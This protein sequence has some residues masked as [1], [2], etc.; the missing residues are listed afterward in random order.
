MKE[1]RIEKINYSPYF[2]KRLSRL[3]PE[4]IERAQ[5]KENLFKS[6]AFAPQLNTHKLKGRDKDSWA[7]YI[8]YKYRIKFIFISDTEA[9]FIDV[10]AHDEVY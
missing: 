7:F 10:G 8:D 4:L 2:L 5:E 1:R 9:L 6:N 3:R